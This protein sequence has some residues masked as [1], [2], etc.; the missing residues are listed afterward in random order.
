[1]FIFVI[2]RIMFVIQIFEY[3]VLLIIIGARHELNDLD[4]HSECFF[5]EITGPQLL[6][7]QQ[8]KRTNKNFICILGIIVLAVLSMLI[9][10]VIF[11]ES[12][13]LDALYFLLDLLIILAFAFYS[14][15]VDRTMS[16][17]YP[18]Y[19]ASSRYRF[20]AF[21]LLM[22]TAQIIFIFSF[23]MIFASEG[24][25]Y[26]DDPSDGTPTLKYLDLAC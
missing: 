2:N 24:K 17:N 5:G 19:F 11:Y 25:V 1:M 21:N 20:R 4:D 16:E 10:S 9:S 14:I 8:E 13:A 18:E 23:K 26:T 15:R 7:R 12:I 22:I 6:Y 3:K